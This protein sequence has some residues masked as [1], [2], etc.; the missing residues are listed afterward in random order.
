MEITEDILDQISD[1]D[2]FKMFKNNIGNMSK[3]FVISSFGDCEEVTTPANK[4]TIFLLI[5]GAVTILSDERTYKNAVREVKKFRRKRE[6]ALEAGE[7][8]KKTN[9]PLPLSDF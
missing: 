2:S 3:N 4:L 1:F 8:P 6:R 7:E 9:E 5:K